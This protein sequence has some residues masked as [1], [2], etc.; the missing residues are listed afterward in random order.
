MKPSRTSR[1]A[2]R[3]QQ[4]IFSGHDNADRRIA[5]SKRPAF[6]AEEFVCLSA[7]CH[8]FARHVW[9]R[10]GASGVDIGFPMT[11]VVT[12]STCTRCG[13]TSIW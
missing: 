9:T 3:W 7:Q 12:V 2:E 11:P 8:A 6:L 1:I 5:A 10:V 4:A 13:G